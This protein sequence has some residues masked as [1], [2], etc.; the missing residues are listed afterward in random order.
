MGKRGGLPVKNVLKPETESKAAEEDCLH[1]NLGHRP[2]LLLGKGQARGACGDNMASSESVP[3][4]AFSSDTGTLSLAFT[5][6]FWPWQTQQM[7]T[8][9]DP[10]IR[11]SRPFVAQEDNSL[12]G[13][14]SQIQEILDCEAP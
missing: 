9:Q 2:W 14:G 12:S 4:L 13:P 1:D 3:R 5:S 10:G 11:H 6:L 7:G 8:L